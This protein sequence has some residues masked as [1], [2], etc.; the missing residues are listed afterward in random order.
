MMMLRGSD[1]G[2]RGEEGWRDAGRKPAAIGGGVGGCAVQCN[3]MRCLLQ[4]HAA[5]AG[6][7]PA[8]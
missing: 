7:V 4:H 8:V 1:A 5:A 2:R 6:A 3:E